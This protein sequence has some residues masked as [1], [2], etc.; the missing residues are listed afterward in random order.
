MIT[1]SDEILKQTLEEVVQIYLIPKFLSLGMNASGEWIKALRVEVSDGKG[2]I[3]G[4]GYTYQL[5]NGRAPGNKPPVT[6]L[7]NWVQ[8]KIGKSGREALGI[9]FAIQ[10]KIAKEGTEY[11]PNG[12]DLLEVLQSKEVTQYIYTKIG[13][14]ISGQ[15][16]S[17]IQRRLKNTFNNGNI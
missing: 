12:T 5:V 4:K 7:F 1:V 3:K 15:I 6:P 10:N 13:D 14:N 16:K 17:E 11:Y 9:A 8:Q 2:Y